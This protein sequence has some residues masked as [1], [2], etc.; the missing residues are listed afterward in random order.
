MGVAWHMVA[1]SIKDKDD[2]SLHCSSVAEENPVDLSKPDD[3]RDPLDSRSF[4]FIDGLGA[5]RWIALVAD[6]Y[7][8]LK[9]G[10]NPGKGDAN[11][12]YY[13]NGLARNAL[14]Q[15]KAAGFISFDWAHHESHHESLRGRKPCSKN[16]L[17]PTSKSR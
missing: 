14:E 16:R 4:E 8:F 6:H 15:S 3:A 12:A 7:G 1:S 11:A 5:S 10:E 9:S 13:G 2:V 17:L